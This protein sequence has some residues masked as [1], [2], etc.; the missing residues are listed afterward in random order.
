VVS[1]NLRGREKEVEGAEKEFVQGKK[2]GYIKIY[3]KRGEPKYDPSSNVHEKKKRR[4]GLSR[5]IGGGR[6]T[7]VGQLGGSLKRRKGEPQ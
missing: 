1:N 3:L 7:F 6:L 4:G 2:G 5:V